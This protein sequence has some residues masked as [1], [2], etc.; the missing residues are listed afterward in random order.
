MFGIQ[1]VPFCGK[2]NSAAENE[3]GSPF[4]LNAVFGVC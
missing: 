3:F 1:R 4:G 2:N